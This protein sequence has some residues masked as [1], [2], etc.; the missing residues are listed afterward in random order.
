MSR[1]NKLSQFLSGKDVNRVIHIGA[2]NGGEEINFYNSLNAKFV[3]WIEANPDLIESLKTNLEKGTTFDSV[4]FNSLIT[5][6]VGEITDFH[7]YY[8]QDNTGMSSIFKKVSGSV[9][10][11]TKEE[12]EKRYYKGT[13]Q[14][15]SDTLDNILSEN[16]IDYDF[17]LINIDLQGAELIAFRGASKLLENSKNVNSEVTF[18]THDYDGGVYFS[19]LKEHLEEYG[20]KYVG[21]TDVCSDGSWGDSFFSK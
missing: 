6:K 12:N 21:E 15:K 1:F 7:L 8:W 14:I 19:Q 18:H 9:G 4:V 11:E 16:N 10:R 17:D 5:D 20:Y 2:G 13:L 3:V